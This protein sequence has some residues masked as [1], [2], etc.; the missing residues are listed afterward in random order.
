MSHILAPMVTKVFP[1]GR[2]PHAHRLQLHLDNCRVHFSRAT[3]QFITENDVG[4]VPHQPYSLDLAPSDFWMF[5]HVKISL[6]DQIF[7]ELEQLLEVLTE[8][9]NEI[10]PPEVIAVFIH[11]AERVRWVLENNGDYYHE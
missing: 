6:G 2:I 5:G 4:H 7:H 8:F 9:L 11:W 1:R 10:Q 3:E